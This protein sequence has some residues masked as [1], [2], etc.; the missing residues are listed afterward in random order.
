MPVSVRTRIP[1]LLGVHTSMVATLVF[2]AVF[3]YE[4][5]PSF[6][7][8]PFLKSTQSSTKSTMTGS[9]DAIGLFLV[10]LDVTCS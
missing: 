4:Y 9:S 10:R 2:C 5:S 8:F 6:A 3:L 1:Y 7:D